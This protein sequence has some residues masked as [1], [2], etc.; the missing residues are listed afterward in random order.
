MCTPDISITDE[1]DCYDLTH[2]IG[3]RSTDGEI[4]TD[5]KVS[6]ENSTC[7]SNNITRH[8][9]SCQTDINAEICDIKEKKQQ[10][11]P[12]TFK[13]KCID[14]LLNVT[15]ITKL[16]SMLLNVGCLENFVQLVTHIAEGTISCMNIA[17]SLCLDVTKLLSCITTIAMRFC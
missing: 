12:K 5:E 10:F 9:I 1:N 4:I 14:T 13:E 15:L 2:N 16:V 8:D 3:I 17:F 11:G 7:Q 6:T